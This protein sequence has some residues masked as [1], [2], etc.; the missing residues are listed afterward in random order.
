MKWDGD[1]FILHGL[2]VDNMSTVPTSDHL[3]EEFMSLYSADFDVSHV[4]GGDLM[5]S[6]LGLEVE[7]P[8][9]CIKPHLDTYIQELIAEHQLILPKFLQ[10]KKVPMSPGL[11][12][13]T[14]DCQCLET[15]D[16]VV[17]KQYCS[18]VAKV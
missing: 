8:D 6:F 15:P 18:I 5:Q 9:C 4:T 2:F 17:Q 13:E 3:K 11:V 7:Q 1:D 14:N 10:L 12:L 16:P